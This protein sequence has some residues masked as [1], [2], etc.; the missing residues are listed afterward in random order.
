MR[1][2]IAETELAST[3][4]RTFSLLIT[5]SDICAWWSADHAMVMPKLDG[6]WI[7]QW[8]KDMD[9]PDYLS[10]GT[11]TVYEPGKCLQLSDMKYSNKTGALP[12]EIDATVRFEICA[13][14]SGSKLCVTQEGFPDDPIADEFYAG[15][16]IGWRETLDGMKNYAATL[17][18]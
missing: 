9:D 2:H 17:V 4:D 10:G 5:P 1:K 7:A 8:G 15:C 12:F 6:L 3:C 16:E 13:N 18:T 11:I 14:E